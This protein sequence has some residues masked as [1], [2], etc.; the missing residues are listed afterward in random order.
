MKPLI[1]PDCAKPGFMG[2]LQSIRFR[3]TLSVLL[4]GASKDR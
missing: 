4:V 2:N 1:S 3:N